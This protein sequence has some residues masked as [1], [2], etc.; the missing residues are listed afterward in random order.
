[1]QQFKPWTD[2]YFEP[3]AV[4]NRREPVA[5]QISPSLVRV[6]KVSNNKL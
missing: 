5:P 1:M 4:A 3:S 2:H 6:S